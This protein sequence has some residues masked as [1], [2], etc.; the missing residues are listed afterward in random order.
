MELEF[1]KETVIYQKK[2]CDVTV[3]HEQTQEAIVPDALPDVFEILSTYSNVCLRG[4]DTESGRVVVTGVAET[5]V[6]F[7]TEG[8]GRVRSMAVNVPFTVSADCAEITNESA[9]IAD[10]T[11]LSAETKLINPRKVLV[12][13][14]L[15]AGLKCYNDAQICV[16]CGADGEGIE[17]LARTSKAETV[18]SVTE[19]TFII[20]DEYG[21][22]GSKAPVGN[23]LACTSRLYAEDVK[24]IGTKLIISGRVGSSVIYLSDSGEEIE[25]ADFSTMFSQVVELPDQSDDC[26]SQIF[27]M[28]TGAYY[29]VAAIGGAKGISAEIHVVAQVETTCETDITYVAD[30]FGTTRAVE[31]ELCCVELSERAEMTEVSEMLRGSIALGSAADRILRSDYSASVVS[32]VR[33]ENGIEANIRAAASVLYISQGV[34]VGSARGNIEGSVVL[35]VSND[36]GLCVTCKTGDEIYVTPAGN[37]LEI[38]VPIVLGISKNEKRTIECVVNASVSE[39]ERDLSDRPSVILYKTQ[40]SD[41]MWSIAKR[42]GTSRLSIAEA[43]SLDA[44][45]TL[46]KGTL[47]LIPKMR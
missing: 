5:S 26:G 25:C 22:S 37:E 11:V 39:D 28:L 1:N 16:M 2:V 33:T 40:E 46:T 6:L 4:K 8:G 27:L 10:V 20:S 3:T 24:V 36:D 29:N 32:V 34:E 41:D 19:K 47:L 12:K 30:I 9:V 21:I 18:K 7:S 17:A 45:D 38:C 23:I 35:P 13:L 15:C 14:N 44:A 31:C 42:F 43:N